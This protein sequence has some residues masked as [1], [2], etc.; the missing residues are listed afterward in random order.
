MN[1]LYNLTM[2][3]IT[4]VTYPINRLAESLETRSHVSK[5]AQSSCSISICSRNKCVHNFITKHQEEVLHSCFWSPIRMKC[6]GDQRTKIATFKIRNMI[7]WEWLYV[8]IS[9]CADRKILNFSD[10]KPF[11]IWKLKSWWVILLFILPNVT[12]ISSI[13]LY[14]TKLWFFL[15][16][17]ITWIISSFVRITSR[18][19]CRLLSFLLRLL[20]WLLFGLLTSRLL[21]IGRL[22]I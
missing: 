6:F 13:Y 19:R 20:F 8:T 14:F 2:V 15:V 4:R 16:I 18:F 10:F 9:C 3:G 17:G 7:F 21:L 22:A 1:L 5:K 12:S 11:I